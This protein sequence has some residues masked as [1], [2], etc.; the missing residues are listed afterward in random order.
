MTSNIED[1]DLSV[2]AILAEWGERGVVATRKN[3]TNAERREIHRLTAEREQKRR[4]GGVQRLIKDG[5]VSKPL[6]GPI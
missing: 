3:R 4:L 6:Y 1:H 2:G 5:K